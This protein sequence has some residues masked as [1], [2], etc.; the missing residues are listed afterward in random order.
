MAPTRGDLDLTPVTTEPPVQILGAGSDVRPDRGR[1]VALE[2]E[3][4]TT[5]RDL[6]PFSRDRSGKALAVLGATRG[7]G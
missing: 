7:E 4:S 3:N 1:S 2:Y 5:V 6:K